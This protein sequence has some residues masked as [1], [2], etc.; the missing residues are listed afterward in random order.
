LV[1]IAWFHEPVLLGRLVCIA[2]VVGGI[3]GLQMQEDV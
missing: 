2:L 3:I 1:G